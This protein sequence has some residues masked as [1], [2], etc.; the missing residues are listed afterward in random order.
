[1]SEP[2]STSSGM[3]FC[4]VLT[5]IF[6]VLKLTGL[7]EWS[8]WLVLAPVW[9]PAALVMVMIFL[10]GLFFVIAVIMS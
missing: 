7:I 2:S 6:L 9:I 8:W 5:L 1:M 10:I 3:G 4:G